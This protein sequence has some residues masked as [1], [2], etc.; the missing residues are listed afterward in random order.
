MWRKEGAETGQR[1][2]LTEWS[3]RQMMTTDFTMISD[4]DALE[5]QIRGLGRLAG[6]SYAEATT[7]IERAWS[8]SIVGTRS[9]RSPDGASPGQVASSAAG[10]LATKP[11]TAE[12]AAEFLAPNGAGSGSPSG[13]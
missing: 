9:Q 6:L 8:S 13:A 3:L 1:S 7:H 11:L 4:F 5:L 12:T 2:S 10:T